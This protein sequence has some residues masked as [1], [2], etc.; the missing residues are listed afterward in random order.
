MADGNAL[1]G[2]YPQPPQ[3][4]SG[5]ILASNPLQLIGA[6]NALNQN[7]LF[8]KTFAAKQAVGGAFQN[9]LS[10]DGTVDIGKLS[11]GLQHPDAAFAAPE[12][13]GT[14]LDQR[15]K[16]ISNDT[17]AFGLAAGQNRTVQD[18][19][20]AMAQDPNLT[21]DKV[22]STMA[23]IARNTN[24]PSGMLHS[25]LQTM[26][27]GGKAL[28]NW[29]ANLGNVSIGAGGTASR[30]AGPPSPEG[31]PT[32]VPLGTANISGGMPTALPPGQAES[33]AANQAAYV[34]DQTRSATTL[35]NVRQLETVLPLISQLGNTSFGPGSPEFAK[36]R[37]AL[38]TAGVIDP[39]ASD[40][41][42]RQQA[43]KYLLKYAQGAQNAGRSDQALAT[44]IGSNPNL[45]LTQPANL[46]LVKNQIGMD[47]MDAA[48]PLAFD[49]AHP[50]AS[51]KTKYNTYKANFY[52]GNDQR[53]FTFDLLSPAERRE[54][55]DSLGSPNSAAYK[56]FAKSYQ[57]AKT[58]G[59]ITPGQ[60]NGQ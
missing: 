25:V 54:V 6:M 24:L 20:G 45:D 14:L 32:T 23:T 9:A 40:L 39:N 48:I 42:V 51:D 47:R 29:A 38:T 18:A 8:Q 36:L 35:G 33:L 16:M 28:Q 50:N 58:A 1:S 34:A 60:A 10:P 21:P 11:T 37:G 31:A 46:H 15:G 2:L 57:L 12:A 43:G 27:N 41:Q 4:G 56:K 3:A 44:A 59:F 49:S 53:A 30:V 26:P 7:A 5:N 19:I 22:R 55:I 17:A 13:I 52:Q